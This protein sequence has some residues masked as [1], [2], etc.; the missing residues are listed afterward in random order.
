[1]PLSP[2]LLVTP[3]EHIAEADRQKFTADVA[4]L[5]DADDG[6]VVSIP[7]PVALYHRI[8]GVWLPVSDLGAFHTPPA[9][10][11]AK[12][13]PAES[14]FRPPQFVPCDDGD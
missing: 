14:T 6:Q 9:A 7:F 12:P 1:M 3:L 13:E 11:Q 10:P 2:P 8:D 5:A 4:D